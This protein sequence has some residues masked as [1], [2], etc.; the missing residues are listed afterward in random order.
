ME[1]FREL[2]DKMEEPDV[3][4]DNPDVELALSLCGEGFRIG[5]L[6]R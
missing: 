5:L 1:E 4:L 3:L 6:C 2:L